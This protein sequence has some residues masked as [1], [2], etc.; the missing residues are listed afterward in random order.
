MWL[1]RRCAATV[2]GTAGSICN[3]GCGA[4]KTVLGLISAISLVSDRDISPQFAP[5]RLGD[6][7]H[8]FADITAARRVLGYEPR[9]DFDTGIALTFRI[10]ADEIGG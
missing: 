2:D 1:T 4:P 3:I 6:V 10:V 7:K 8:S 5:P 9:I